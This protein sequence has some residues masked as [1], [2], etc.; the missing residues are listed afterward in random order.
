MR[1]DLALGEGEGMTILFVMALWGRY[2]GWERRFW[3]L[4]GVM[5][6]LGMDGLVQAQKGSQRHCS[7]IMCEMLL[8]FPI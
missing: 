7:E 4:L 2:W 5:V 6:G 3:A 8:Q 1:F